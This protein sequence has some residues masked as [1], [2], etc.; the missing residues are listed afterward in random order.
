MTELELRTSVVAAAKGWLGCKESDGTHQPI[1]DLYNSHSPLARGYAVQYTDAWC[2]TFVSAVAVQLGLTDIIPTECSCPKQVL[3]F[4]G[5]DCWQEDDGYTPQIGDIIYYDWSDSGTGDNEGSPN[6]VGIV[7]SVVGTA[8]TVIEGN[9]SNT[10]GYRAIEVDGQYIR[11]YGIPN[12]TAMATE[13][14]IAV[15]ESTTT[16]SN[17]AKESWEKA[18][19][20]GIFDGTSPQGCFTRE[21]A[22]V[23]L[24]RL[25]LLE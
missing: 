3:L 24:D 7:V 16:P 17:W 19:A 23:V 13:E 14:V 15:S 11:G 25:G 20:Q 9:K 6:H 4:Q 22:A 10:V 5:L 18:V 21:Q 2:A 8:I 12:Y 1:I